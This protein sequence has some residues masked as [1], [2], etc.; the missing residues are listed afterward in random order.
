M[1]AR[2][3]LP[4]VSI[5]TE[6]DWKR[7]QQNLSAALLARLDTE[8]EFHG[9]SGDKDALLPHVD[10]FL[11]ALFDIARPN[12]RIN[13]RSTDEPCVDEDDVEPFDEALDR[14]IWSLSDQRLK[15]DKEI[16]DRRRSRPEAIEKLVM[17][18]L[19]QHHVCN[20][21][22]LEK[23][24]AHADINPKQVDCELQQ[25]LLNAVPLV[26][27]LIQSIQT[28]QSRANRINSISAEVKALKP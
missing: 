6:Q 24:N 1:D 10:Q 21:E 7:I 16:A 14:H 11:E 17:E 12:L 22:V 13:G 4:K 20:L 27:R 9:Q 18:S 23:S 26:H 28:Q 19:A 8:L 3:D 25:T 2:E 15:W 5:E